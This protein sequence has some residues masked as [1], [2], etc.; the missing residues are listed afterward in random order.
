MPE[1]LDKTFF[2]LPL[3]IREHI[4]R[5]ALRGIVVS[6]ASYVRAQTSKSTTAF[7]FRACRTCYDEAQPIF[8][9]TARFIL[10]DLGIGHEPE[11]QDGLK[12]MIG[13][14]QL[15]LLIFVKNP[16][17]VS[18]Q[19]NSVLDQL[20]LWQ[21]TVRTFTISSSPFCVEVYERRR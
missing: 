6:S 16:N 11:I 17:M 3:K 5:Y 15:Q 20:L 10:G 13:V 18:N 21:G 19:R 8:L 4:Y 9:Q 14:S 12:R 2:D 1:H 7:I